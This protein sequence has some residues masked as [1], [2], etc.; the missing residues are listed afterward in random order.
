M[1]IYKY[2]YIYF[3]HNI[4]YIYI[5]SKCL[6]IGKIRYI[7]GIPLFNR[8][9][10]TSLK[11]GRFQSFLKTVC[12]WLHL[13][14]KKLRFMEKLSGMPEVFTIMRTNFTNWSSSKV[15][16]EKN[17]P[18]S[19]ATWRGRRKTKPLSK[20][21]WKN[22]KLSKK[23]M[24]FLRVFQ[25]LRIFHTQNQVSRGTSSQKCAKK[26]VNL[27]KREGWCTDGGNFS[28]EKL[29]GY[30]FSPVSEEQS[31]KDAHF[32]QQEFSVAVDSCF[33]QFNCWWLWTQD[34]HS[35]WWNKFQIW[36]H[37]RGS[38]T[39]LVGTADG[40][41]EREWE[42]ERDVYVYKYIYINMDPPRVCFHQCST[43]VWCATAGDSQSVL[44]IFQGATTACSPWFR[45]F[46]NH[47]FFE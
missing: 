36:I 29:Q 22:M 16:A 23:A 7:K 5:Y 26:E 31:A 32:F 18:K 43:G 15:A 44:M 47:D 38:R 37:L 2:I 4:L 40:A 21:Q 8:V 11:T 34:P 6:F 9:A 13:S 46:L 45:G 35:D 33:L 17:V 25:F 28:T 24:A 39:L 19:G 3:I 1:C 41:T 14:G 30:V 27:W 12:S 20:S 10:K 42:R